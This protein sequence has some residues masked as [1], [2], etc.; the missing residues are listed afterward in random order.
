MVS[1]VKCDSK[2]AKGPN[3]WNVVQ[4]KQPNENLYHDLYDNFFLILYI[5]GRKAQNFLLAP[6]K[7]KMA[8]APVV[9]DVD[10]EVSTFRQN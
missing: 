9:S 10:K 8:V 4:Q 5:G 6:G 2:E 7:K 3:L 1:E